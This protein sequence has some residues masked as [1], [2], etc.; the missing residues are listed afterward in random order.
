MKA[1]DES[2][3]HNCS[4]AID[5][6]PRRKQS[7]PDKHM[8]MSPVESTRKRGNHSTT[9]NDNIQFAELSLI[10]PHANSTSMSSTLTGTES[11]TSYGP[12]DT[13]NVE[14]A[15]DDAHP[16]E[17]V[18]QSYE[19]MRAQYPVVDN[20]NNATSV[21]N[22]NP[23]ANAPLGFSYTQTLILDQVVGIHPV[24]FLA[25]RRSGYTYRCLK[26]LFTTNLRVRFRFNR[27]CLRP[28]K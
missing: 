13:I 5:A 7:G 15:S 2:P 20:L 22:S 6:L 1:S 23:Y 24:L 19:T 26:T 10:G 4:E 18:F 28:I 8:L 17:I 27:S 21:S 25:I 14:I 9:A 12:L 16:Q 3:V 11:I